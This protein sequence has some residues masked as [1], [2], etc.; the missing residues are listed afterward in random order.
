[1]PVPLK[2]RQRKFGA[3]DRSIGFL[4]FLI[5]SLKMVF[6]SSADYFNVLQPPDCRQNVMSSLQEVIV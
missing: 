2:V 6:I 5:T 4:S 3:V 1:M